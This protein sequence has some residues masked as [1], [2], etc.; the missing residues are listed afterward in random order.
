MI[1]K[2]PKNLRERKHVSNFRCIRHTHKQRITEE[3]DASSG[4]QIRRNIHCRLLNSE[5]QVKP[6][7][8]LKRKTLSRGLTHRYADIV[9]IVLICTFSVQASDSGNGNLIASAGANN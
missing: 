7:D 4:F 6:L 8:L 9:T 1:Y 5:Q 2:I 3:R